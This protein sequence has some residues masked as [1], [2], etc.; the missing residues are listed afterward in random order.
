MKP[1]SAHSIAVAVLV[2]GL[3]AGCGDDKAADTSPSSTTPATPTA[4]GTPTPVMDP[5]DGGNYRPQLDPTEI[6]AV[7]DNPYMP[8]TIGSRWQYEGDSDGKREVIEVVVTPERKTVMGIS[9]FVVSDTVTVNGDIVEDTVD[10]FTQ[11]TAGNVWYLGEET[12]EYD[13]GVVVSTEGSW[14]AGVDGALAGIV[15]P[16]EPVVGDVYRQEFLAAEAEDMMMITAI[17]D[18]MT[19][20]AGAYTD[21]VM[22]QDWTPLDAEVIEEKAYAPGVG[23]VH[24]TK[25]AGGSGSA[26]LVEYTPGS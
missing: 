12:K 6:A 10:W 18:S 9:A 14:E 3:L 19:V 17:D 13:N 24:E 21:L 22:T 15:M 26:E 2:A 1:H 4:S 5:G 25:V 8:L 7:I 16:A 11:D 23:L 20:R